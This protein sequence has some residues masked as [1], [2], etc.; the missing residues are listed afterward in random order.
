MLPDIFLD[1]N[2]PDF[3]FI[4]VKVFHDN[5]NEEIEYNVCPYVGQ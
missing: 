1:L 2:L 4:Q 3:V 5:G